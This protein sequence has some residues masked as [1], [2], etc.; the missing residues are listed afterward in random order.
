MEK[1]E[2][3]QDQLKA[4]YQLC[5]RKDIR[6]LELRIE[7]TDHIAS[8]IEA[9][10]EDDPR[11][12]FKEALHKVYKSFGI[13]GLSE[14]AAEHEKTVTRRFYRAAWLAFQSWLKPPQIFA[15][16]MAVALLFALLVNYPIASLLIVQL[17]VL[18]SIW[19]VAY[20]FWKR[21][22]LKKN[23]DQEDS[24]ILGSL[25]QSGT[26]LYLFYLVPAYQILNFKVEA[27]LHFSQ[28]IHMAFA[29]GLS[30]LTGILIS[31][32][33]RLLSRAKGQQAELLRRLHSFN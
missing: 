12:S 22:Q 8:R 1:R 3:N 30:I 18:I 14:I 24:I 21:W 25:Y 15:F 19:S 29:L 10:W 31:T 16:V 5:K 28:S 20:L 33:Y 6:Y 2:L 26:I 17:N 9:L 4:I 7:L 32:S 27:Y 13:F 23:L 11:L